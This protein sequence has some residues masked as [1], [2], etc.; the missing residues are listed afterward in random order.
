MGNSTLSVLWLGGLF[1]PANAGKDQESLHWGMGTECY[2]PLTPH[3]DSCEAWARLSLKML[4]QESGVHNL[5][6]P[7]WV[8]IF[9]SFLPLFPSYLLDHHDPT[10]PHPPTPAH[11]SH[12]CLMRASADVKLTVTTSNSCRCQQA[13]LL[14]DCPVWQSRDAHQFV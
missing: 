2:W 1:P 13:A 8:S 9:L 6:A 7:P 11:K 12:P 3:T 4:P 14:R 10:L 5:T